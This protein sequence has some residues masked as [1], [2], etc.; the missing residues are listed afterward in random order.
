MTHDR[1][2]PMKL[3]PDEQALVRRIGDLYAAPP[4]SGPHRT[5][6]DA[7]LAERV[8]AR[9]PRTRALVGISFAAVAAA[10]FGLWMMVPRGGTPGVDTPSALPAPLAMAAQDDDA[11][12]AMMEP[13]A[14]ADEALPEDYRAIADL[15][16]DE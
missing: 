15:V 4:L 11:I 8:G 13:I 6:F 12:L 7:R 10:S 14:S 5:R 3:A 1:R 16:I 2:D 9:A